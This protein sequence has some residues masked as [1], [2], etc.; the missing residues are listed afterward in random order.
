L[1]YSVPVLAAIDSTVVTAATRKT[2]RR[3]WGIAFLLAFGILVSY[4][5]RVNLSVSKDALFG[6]FGISAVMF[7]FLSSAYN[8]PYM[9]LQIPA[10]LLLDRFGVRRVGVVST[11][12]WTL[13]SFAAASS[14]GVV[15]LFA[16][17]FMLGIGEAPTFP[18]TAKAT[19]YWFPNDERSLATATFDSMAKFSSALGIPLLGLVLLHFGWR[20]NFALTG[21]V[22]VV[23]LAL[24]F[25]FYRNP[26]ADAKLSPA[27]RAYIER[28]GAQPEDPVRAAA[29]APLIYLLRQPK[30]IGLALG[31]GSYNYV[32]YLLL[33]WLPSYLAEAQHLALR[34]SFFYTAVPWL[35]ATIAE[36]IVGGWLVDA[37]IQRGYKAALVRRT[38][39]V[40]G[41]LLGL[42]IFGVAYAHSAEN[43]VFWI[44]VSI[45]GLSIAAPVGWSMPGL[46][47]PRESVGTIGGI[48]NLSNQLS[49]IAAPIVTGFVVAA[50]RNFTWAFLVASAYLLIG[51]AAY[52]FLLGDMSPI[53]EPD[54]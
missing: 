1:H 3:R 54:S 5:D 34:R 45:T 18:G 28:G 33:T 13:A 19:A 7:G 24:F 21:I 43:A 9:L 29:G 32:F 23:Y 11:F 49:G 2:P 41:T 42:G 35:S 8:W 14:I 17:R 10:G 39:L 46:I 44:T 27:E 6:A 51:I 36:L 16:A 30:V 22:S 25:A 47:A 50:T 40:G 4:F 48:M 12:I 37:L 52:V 20:A 38:I 53:P 31:Y 26:S 15:S